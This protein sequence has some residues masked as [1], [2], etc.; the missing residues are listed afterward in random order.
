MTA[1]EQ[2][3]EKMDRLERQNRNLKCWLVG[4]TVVGALFGITGAAPPASEEASFGTISAKKV[5]ITDTDGTERM[6]L[7]LEAGEP[8][9]TMLNHDGERQIYLGIDERWNDAAYLSVCGRSANGDI[10]KQAVLVATPTRMTNTGGFQQQTLP[11]NAQLLLYDL[12]PKQASA[13]GRHLM[14][15]SSGH[16][17][18]L[19]PYIEIRDVEDS[20][21]RQLDL[22]LLTTGPDKQGQRFL[23][24]T[25]PST[26][27]VSATET[28]DD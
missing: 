16:L 24:N 20:G 5:S 10:E 8:T 22:N 18:Q 23:L 13:A 7:E 12:K 4:I 9:L 11:G 3:M 6:I 17:D 27:T 19:K 28:A 21:S 26:T 14:R 1:A 2:L 25:T 15:L